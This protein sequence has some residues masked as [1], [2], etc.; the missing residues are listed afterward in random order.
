[1]EFSPPKFSFLC[2][3]K[4]VLD[5][6]SLIYYHYIMLKIFSLFKKQK[7]SEEN[8]KAAQDSMEALR[9]RMNILNQKAMNLAENYPEQRKEIENCFNLVNQIEPSASV[10]AGKFEQQMG[11][12]ITRVS[13]ECDQ[14]FTTK[15]EKKLTSEIKL[16]SRAVRERQNADLVQEE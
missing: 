16:L 9:A 14:I 10:R 13:T 3:K 5:K 8:Q 6:K 12:A 4:L 7:F 15:D 11:V 2:T 1:M